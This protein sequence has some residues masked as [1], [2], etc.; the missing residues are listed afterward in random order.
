MYLLYTGCIPNASQTQKASINKDANWHSWATT[1]QVD[2]GI[3]S[4]TFCGLKW[5]AQITRLP[6]PAYMFVDGSDESKRKILQEL[7][8]QHNL[9][10]HKIWNG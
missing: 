3:N 2:F 8:K 1:D 6:I 10:N 4:L 7:K 5:K 9:P